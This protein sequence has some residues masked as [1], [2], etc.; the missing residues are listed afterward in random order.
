MSPSF[1]SSP[2]VL[3][4]L[5][6]SQS[7]RAR[8]A[9]RRELEQREMTNLTT[10]IVDEYPRDDDSVDIMEGLQ[11]G[12]SNWTLEDGLVAAEVPV[13]T[14]NI[15]EKTAVSIDSSGVIE[16]NV[17]A[18]SL[19][20]SDDKISGNECS[21]NGT[22]DVGQNNNLANF[23]KTLATSQDN[24]SY[25]F[26]RNMENNNNNYVNLDVFANEGIY[27]NPVQSENT[28]KDLFIPSDSGSDLD[29]PSLLLPDYG[30]HDLQGNEGDN[31]VMES[32]RF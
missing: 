27:S 7:R 4:S 22:K 3:P 21:E 23:A 10:S 19:V 20:T 26:P 2:F 12:A 30:G 6:L 16:T 9:A 32:T 29:A 13:A 17:A 11:R 24:V 8:D 18:E 14:E 25:D 31:V 1:S 28:H 15:L 5:V